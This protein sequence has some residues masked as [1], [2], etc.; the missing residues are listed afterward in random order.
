M[1]TR[2]QSIVELDRTGVLV[3]SGSDQYVAITT[4]TSTSIP[5]LEVC[6]MLSR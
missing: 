2:A 4:T 5:L 1:H 3:F 6:M